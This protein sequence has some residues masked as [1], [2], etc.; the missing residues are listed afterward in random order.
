SNL[1]TEITF[2][3]AEYLFNEKNL[4][5]AQ[6]A[7]GALKN[8]YSGSEFALK[9][10]LRLG[11]ILL[12][13]G[14]FL[15]AADHF[16]E[17]ARDNPGTEFGAQAQYKLGDC[18]LGLNRQRQAIENYQKVADNFPSTSFAPPAMLAIAVTWEKMQ[19]R[20]LSQ[21]ACE[22]LLSRYPKS[23]VA[24]GI[25]LSRGKEALSSGSLTA[26]IDSL[27]LAADAFNGETSAEAQ[28]L[29][30]DCY[31]KQNQFK[32]ATVE[33]LKTAYLFRT[34]TRF[35][36]EAQYLAG[37]SCEAYNQFAEARNAYRRTRE[38]FSATLWAAEAERRLTEIKN[39]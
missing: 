27:R 24:A 4:P 7:Y 3:V 8:T 10:D 34:H 2:Q 18:S 36:A 16:Q 32:E 11:E 14:N 35:A 38:F 25:F 1:T 12:M 13:Q 17:I 20:A 15:A 31:F 39:K 9:S 19:E 22:A 6:K 21:K 23:A 30:G 37:K 5:L 33:Y 28:K 29:L 26:A